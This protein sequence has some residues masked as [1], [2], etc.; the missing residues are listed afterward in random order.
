MSYLSAEHVPKRLVCIAEY[1]FG[2]RW[3]GSLCCRHDVRGMGEIVSVRLSPLL[4]PVIF[5]SGCARS[6]DR[7][8]ASLQRCGL[9][10]AQP[11]CIGTHL[12]KNM[13][14]GQL[15]Q[16]GHAGRQLARAQNG[17]IGPDDLMRAAGKVDD[18]K[19]RVEVAKAAGSCSLL[20]ARS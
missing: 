4:A 11:V 3:R 10:D 2:N 13:T 12:E 9:D 5:V 16:L 8:A 15:R 19:V 7:I 18:I 17:D 14:L 6:A 20:E 1:N